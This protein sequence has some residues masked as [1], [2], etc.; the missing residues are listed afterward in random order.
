MKNGL[1]LK[2]TRRTVQYYDTRGILAPSALTEGGRR[3]Y[4]DDE[5]KKLKTICFLRERGFSRQTLCRSLRR[6]ET[7]D[8]IDRVAFC[9]H[10]DRESVARRPDRQRRTAVLRFAERF[11]IRRRRQRQHA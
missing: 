6:R 5:L 10:F 1:I 4:S 3:L 8:R 11:L 7:D 9:G 2:I